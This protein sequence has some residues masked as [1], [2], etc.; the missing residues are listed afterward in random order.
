M[1]LYHNRSPFLSGL[2]EKKTY[3]IDHITKLG[4]VRKEIEMFSSS[5]ACYAI[6][7][8]NFR[9]IR[10]VWDI[11]DLWKQIFKPFVSLPLTFS[12]VCSD[13]FQEISQDNLHR[14]HVL[15]FMSGYIKTI[16]RIVWERFVC[17]SCA[18]NFHGWLTY[19]NS[20]P[21]V[22]TKES[23]RKLFAEGNKMQFFYMRK[24]FM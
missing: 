15:I 2:T 18:K 23:L 6:W 24:K 5:S 3:V 10:H 20:S 8:Q 21:G 7:S 12:R 11:D 17:L 9:L 19:A 1:Y 13:F 4:F 22:L 14:V 16:C